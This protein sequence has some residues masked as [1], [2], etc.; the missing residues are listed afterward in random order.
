[1]DRGETTRET[2]NLDVFTPPPDPALPVTP[3]PTVTQSVTTPPAAPE[4]QL[5]ML[6]FA[7][8]QNSY[9]AIA[10]PTD[11][12]TPMQIEL[13]QNPTHTALPAPGGPHRPK[14]SRARLICQLNPNINR[15]H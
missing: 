11:F 9:L 13:P 7:Q 10:R 14:A 12:T 1:M 3:R 8:F 4:Q 2:I 6:F 15:I 5:F